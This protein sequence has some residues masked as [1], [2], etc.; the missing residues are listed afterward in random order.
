MDSVRVMAEAELQ[1]PFLSHVWQ[2]A[3]TPLE[4]RGDFFPGWA[5]EL[6]AFAPGDV[7]F[8]D[9]GSTAG[10]HHAVVVSRPEE[11]G[12]SSSAL[13]HDEL[14]VGLS[15]R[16][17]P[18]QN[19]EVALQIDGLLVRVPCRRLVRV[20]PPRRVLVVHDTFSYRRLARTQVG[21]D[22]GVVELGSSLGEPRPK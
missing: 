16:T 5:V 13:Q 15:R 10:H 7:V 21:Q 18:Q 2:C 3:Q 20:V 8:L 12:V 11:S 19:H 9:T 17:M 4:R 1:L 6:N 22:D 14:V